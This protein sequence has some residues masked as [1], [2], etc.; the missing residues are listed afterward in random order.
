MEENIKI[1]SP[2]ARVVLF[3]A[4]HHSTNNKRGIKLNSIYCGSPDHLTQTPP[5][6]PPGPCQSRP[7]QT[8]PL[9]SL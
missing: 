2:M 7:A 6:P 5:P 4:L 8:Q 1:T 9:V 3:W